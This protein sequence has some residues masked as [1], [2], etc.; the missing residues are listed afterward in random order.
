MEIISCPLSGCRIKQRFNTIEATH[1]HTH[2]HT[3]ILI[4]IFLN[5]QKIIKLGRNFKI[6]KNQM[7][8]KERPDSLGY[9]KVL[10]GGKVLAVNAYIKPNKK[11][12]SKAKQNNS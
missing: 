10:L 8:I 1:T 6:S 3:W 7:N 12:K 2:T 9:S 11:A 4:N 5:G